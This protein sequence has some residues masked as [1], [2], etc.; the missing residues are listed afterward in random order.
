MF[1]ACYSTLPK[2]MIGGHK[3]PGHNPL[4]QNPPVGG[5]ARRNPQD[6]T[7]CSI[8]TQCTMSFSVTG[9]GVLKAKF[10]DITPGSEPPVRGVLNQGVMPRGLRPPILKFSFQVGDVWFCAL[11]LIRPCHWTE[12]YDLVGY[13]RVV[14]SGHQ[15]WYSVPFNTTT[16]TA[17]LSF[18]LSG[19]ILSW[20]CFVFHCQFIIIIIIIIINIIFKVA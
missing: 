7:P 14:M 4:G 17:H 2:L 19:N 3:P 8:R 20:N 16:K 12:D 10:Q 11:P 6:I 18:R 15:I 9:K 13:V 5:K 1:G